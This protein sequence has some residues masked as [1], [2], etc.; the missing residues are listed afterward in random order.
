MVLEGQ[1][2]S[3][4][5]GAGR[6]VPPDAQYLMNVV[7][8]PLTKAL[9]EIVLKQPADPIEYLALWLYNFSG[10][11]KQQREVWSS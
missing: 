1:Q 11:T 5:A 3:S 6:K 10:V 9:A 8:S 7:A 4:A 2:A